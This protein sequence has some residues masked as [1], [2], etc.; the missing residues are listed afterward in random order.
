MA[1]KEEKSSK[2]KRSGDSQKEGII[3]KK[4]SFVKS[5]TSSDD[6]G[7]KKKTFDKSSKGGKKPQYDNKSDY[8]EEK[9]EPKTKREAR[10]QAK[11]G[12]GFIR[13]SCFWLCE[14]ELDLFD[15]T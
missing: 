15:Y 8:A 9:K 5:K 1:A 13:L 4:P 6:D 2:R 14:N 7:L 3:S 11:A 12:A 10:L